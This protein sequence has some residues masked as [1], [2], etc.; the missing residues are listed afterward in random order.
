MLSNVAAAVLLAPLLSSVANAFPP[1]Y[2]GSGKNSVGKAIY[3]LGNDADNTVISLPIKSDG[4]VSHGSKTSTGGQGSNIATNGDT[5]MSQAPDSL[6]SQGAVAVSGKYVFAVNAGSN[7]LS[8]FEA[9]DERD[10][11]KLRLLGKPAHLPGEFPVTVGAS[12]KHQLACVGFSGAKAGVSCVPY[13]GRGLG[14]ADAL[15][16][17]DLGQ[18]TPPNSTLNLVGSTIF[19][20]NEDYVYTTVRGTNGFL[21]SFPVEF[22]GKVSEKGARPIT[23]FKRTLF[24]A[25]SLPGT[26]KVV[27]ADTVIGADILTV[28]HQKASIEEVTISGQKAT[29]W[30]TASEKTGS[31][32]ATDAGVNRLVEFDLDSGKIIKILNLNNG[33]P[34]MFDAAVAGNYIYALYAGNGTLPGTVTVFD[35]KGQKGYL[36]QVQVYNLEG[37][38]VTPNAIGMAVMA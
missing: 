19:S 30:V 20:G 35:T 21:S 5:A 33:N 25:E 17:F 18:T 15:R 16:P 8:M 13:S 24:G 10:S 29:C 9:Y 6:G 26:D 27:V 12:E 34:G 14:H 36:K 31:G 11:S 37:M 22:F 3:I 38:G 1:S 23:N 4:T 2:G 28:D 7:S 32:Y